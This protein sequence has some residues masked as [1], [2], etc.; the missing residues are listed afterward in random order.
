MEEKAF[1]IFN[2]VLIFMLMILAAPSITRAE[3]I[4]ASGFES[5]TYTIMGEN[6]HRAKDIRGY[7]ST[8]GYNWEDDLEAGGRTFFMNYADASD[9]DPNP[10]MLGSYIGPDPE[11]PENNVLCTWQDDAEYSKW[12]ARVQGE[13]KDFNAPE[14]YY[15]VRIRIDGDVA[16]V[17]GKDWRRWLMLGMEVRPTVDGKNH[18]LSV[19]MHRRKSDNVQVWGFHIKTPNIGG[20]SFGS[21]VE[22]EFDK[23]Q[24]LE[25]YAK[26]GDAENG[27]VRIVVNGDTVADTVIETVAGGGMW[28]KVQPFKVYGSLVDVVTDPEK[29][30]KD[31]VKV[32][33]DD[34]EIWDSD[35]TTTIMQKPIDCRTHIRSDVRNYRHHSR[36]YT[37]DGKVLPINKTFNNRNFQSIE[38]LSPAP[39]I[40]TSDSK[41]KT[42][43]RLDC[44]EAGNK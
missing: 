18:S 2:D 8:T 29:G 44:F 21:D 35:P 38:F 26:A 7:D 19:R 5:G 27:H 1:H 4:F 43:L 37:L 14:V 20:N 23:W 6:N 39:G 40:Y 32:W 3:K 25:F 28:G 42:L 33:F 41:E 9:G 36:W 11:N 13:Y 16:V 34:F 31:T 22:V 10:S 12:W 24:T 15:K 30:N 17:N